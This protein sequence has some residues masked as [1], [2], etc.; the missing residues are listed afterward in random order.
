MARRILVMTALAAALASATAACGGSSHGG[1]PSPSALAP[2]STQISVPAP[3]GLTSAQARAIRRANAAL[4]RGL[5]AFVRADRRC[6]AALT[7]PALTGYSACILPAGA[8]Q[9]AAAAAS[10][11]AVRRGL[12][13]LRALGAGEGRCA[14]ALAAYARVTGR[15]ASGSAAV[16]AAARL[17]DDRSAFARDRRMYP[18]IR[19]WSQALKPLAAG[20]GRPVR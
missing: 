12:G 19:A 9:A 14:R 15:V 8:G 2:A 16:A 6:V 3:A 4:N 13:E 11:A 7:S 17:G 1:P 5:A 20:C 10:V 18:V